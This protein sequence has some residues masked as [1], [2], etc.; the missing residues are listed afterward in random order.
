MELAI[1][2][3]ISGRT[4]GSVSAVQCCRCTVMFKTRPGAP[5]TPI[6]CLPRTVQPGR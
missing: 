6:Q 1:N 5:S 3:L 4:V 2:F